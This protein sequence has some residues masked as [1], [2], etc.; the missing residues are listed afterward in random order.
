MPD[1][2]LFPDRPTLKQMREFR[3]P[4]SADAVRAYILGGPDRDSL[5]LEKRH[6]PALFMGQLRLKTSARFSYLGTLLVHVSYKKRI[7]K[8]W[9]KRQVAPPRLYPAPVILTVEQSAPEEAVVR[10]YA[11]EDP[12]RWAL[13]GGDPM[14]H[15]T[16]GMRIVIDWWDALTRGWPAHNEQQAKRKRTYGPRIATLDLCEKALRAW[17]DDDKPLPL[18]AQLAGVDDQ[19]VLRYLPLLVKRL[20]PARQQE[21]IRAIQERGKGKYLD[22]D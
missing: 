19:T 12:E 22:T 18:A 5:T 3:F 14:L 8:R 2:L 21:Y 10:L 4:A 9:F 6:G 7:S 13:F 15:I 16:V 20:P 17:L 1:P 11:D